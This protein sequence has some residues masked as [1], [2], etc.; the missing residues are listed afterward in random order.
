[1]AE[2][3]S[4]KLR[5]IVYNG[6]DELTTHKAMLEAAGALDDIVAEYEAKIN[7]IGT[8]A[9]KIWCCLV[10]AT[11][12]MKT[13]AD[14]HM[15]CDCCEHLKDDGTCGNPDSDAGKCWK[16]RGW[17]IT[18]KKIREEATKEEKPDENA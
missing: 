1:M 2:N 7:T 5:N 12:D 16:W 9:Y 4:A 13:M 14:I 6:A 18:A 8:N 15:V 17:G 10:S 11:S 3:I